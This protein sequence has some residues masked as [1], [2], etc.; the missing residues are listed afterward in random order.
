MTMPV[1]SIRVS[2]EQ[3]LVIVRQ[4]TRQLASLLGFE[5]QD[6]TRIATAVSEICRNAYGYAGGG[7]IEF[8]V[9]TSAS[10]QALVIRVIDRGPGIPDV[11]AILQGRYQSRS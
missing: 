10:A 11:D 6:Q 1:L 8:V 3:D 2:L 9:E 5:P 7:R 4:R